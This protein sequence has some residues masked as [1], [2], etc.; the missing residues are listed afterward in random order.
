MQNFYNYK[1]NLDCTFRADANL[2][3]EMILY[4]RALFNEQVKRR[5]EKLSSKASR[6]IYTYPKKVIHKTVEL[7]PHSLQTPPRNR[8]NYREL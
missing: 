6:D 2:W 3:F 7:L 5:I 1:N 8:W 4:A